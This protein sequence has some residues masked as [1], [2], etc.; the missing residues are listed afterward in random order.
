MLDLR[1]GLRPNVLP[2][3][4]LAGVLLLGSAASATTRDCALGFL[5]W[6]VVDAERAPGPPPRAR[7]ELFAGYKPDIGYFQEE[8]RACRAA[9]CRLSL[10]GPTLMLDALVR[11]SGDARSDDAFDLGLSYT[12]IPVMRDLTGNDAGFAGQLG[13]I[14]PGDGALS[15]GA[16]R[17]TLRR[18]SLLYL[19]RSKYLVSSF[20]VGL[21]FP[22]SRGMGATFTGGDG[23][24][25]TL[26]GRLGVQFPLSPTMSL[27]IASSYG[28]VWYGPRFG[29]AAYVGGYGLNLQALL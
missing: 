20:G 4:A 9:G 23:P 24:R 8:A 16:V 26:G 6:C 28:V 5:R 2:P 21:A 1:R 12:S 18:N 27:G 22:I 15:W 13:P 7:V 29:D 19:V 17:V 11:V 10:D 3:W 25:L 14:A